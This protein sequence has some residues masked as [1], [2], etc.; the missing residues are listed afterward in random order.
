VD[1]ETLEAHLPHQASNNLASPV[2]W[3][4]T[5]RCPIAYFDSWGSTALVKDLRNG[6]TWPKDP[7]GM[8]CPCFGIR[9]EEIEAEA[10]LH[11]TDL[12][13]DLIARSQGP[14]AR[15]AITSPAGRCCV[16]L[17]RRLYYRVSGI[18]REDVVS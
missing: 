6:A 18:G 14:E 5:P 3:C 8:L 12:I 11:R 15:C 13:R 9:P 4:P 17:A 16:P 10:A 2:F 1:S 7:G